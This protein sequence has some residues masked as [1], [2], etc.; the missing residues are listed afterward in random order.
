MNRLLFGT[1][2][3]SDGAIYRSVAL[4]FIER[5]ASPDDLIMAAS[6]DIRG[7]AAVYNDF[8]VRARTSSFDGLVLLQDDVEIHQSGFRDRVLAA[9]AQDEVGILGAI[10]ARG[11]SS[12]EWWR[13]EG[14]GQVYETRRP[15][16]FAERS[17]QVDAVDGLLLAMSPRA[18]ERLTFDQVNFPRFHG[19][20]VDICFAARHQRLRVEVIPLELFHRTEGGFKDVQAFEAAEQRFAA[21]YSGLFDQVLPPKQQH[22]LE[23]V[24]GPRIFVPLRAL[25]RWCFRA[26][27][28]AQELL[29]AASGLPLRLMRR[30]RRLAHRGDAASELSLAR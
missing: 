19:Y 21:K 20:D 24:L 5:A 13:G 28:R 7:I 22:P 2:F 4:P 14:V 27:V 30:G 1:C 11:V 17:G 9:L 3:R 15:I 29:R 8:I 6:G 25:V 10:G 26:K 18:V 23:Q 12:L 16:A